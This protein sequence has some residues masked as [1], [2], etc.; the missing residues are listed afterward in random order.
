[1]KKKMR[2]LQAG[3]MGFHAVDSGDANLKAVPPW[4]NK[5]LCTLYRHLLKDGCMQKETK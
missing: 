4:V 1:M 3:P 5:A 2:R